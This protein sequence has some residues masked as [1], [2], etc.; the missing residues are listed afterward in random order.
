M[1]FFKIGGVISLLLDVLQKSNDKIQKRQAFIFFYIVLHFSFKSIF[2]CEIAM[3]KLIPVPILAL[4]LEFYTAPLQGIRKC[5]ALVSDCSP[6][7]ISSVPG[8][9]AFMTIQLC[10]RS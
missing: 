7:Y 2:L 3:C 10:R 1:R 5:S 8:G 9:V 6:E 4:C